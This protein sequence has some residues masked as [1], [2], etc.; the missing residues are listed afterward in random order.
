MSSITIFITCIHTGTT[1]T[2]PDKILSVGPVFG[3][4]VWA[5]EYACYIIFIY[6]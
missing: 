3:G 1:L 5:V 2:I 4:P 6:N